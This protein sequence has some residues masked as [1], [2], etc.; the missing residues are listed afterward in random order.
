MNRFSFLKDSYFLWWALAGTLLCVLWAAL[1]WMWGDWVGVR[2]DGSI[3]DNLLLILVGIS[4]VSC[5]EEM[6]FRGVVQDYL[7]HRTL[8]S[9]ALNRA[10][11]HTRICTVSYANIIANI[12]FALLHVIYRGVLLGFLVFIPGLL[13]GYVKDRY[14][15]TPAAMVLHVHFNASYILTWAMI[16]G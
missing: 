12:A 15:S 16:G 4:V 2:P 13:F 3:S 8:R 10:V 9:V 7:S 14:R 1:I 11:V 6:F 5:V